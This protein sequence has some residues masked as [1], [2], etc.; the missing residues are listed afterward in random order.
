MKVMVVRYMT[1]CNL[2]DRHKY[3]L[4]FPTSGQERDIIFTIVLRINIINCK[5]Y[6]I[7][8]VIIII[9]IIIISSLVNMFLP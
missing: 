9:I 4:L 7:I 3:L 8:I 5:A 6:F 2:R 1:S